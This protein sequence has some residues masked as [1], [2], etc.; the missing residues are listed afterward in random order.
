M[1]RKIFLLGVGCQKGGTSWLRSQL[2]KHPAINMGFAK[3]Y[4]IFDAL[5]ID[6]CRPFQSRRLEALNTQSVQDRNAGN[7]T[8]LIDFFSN[9]DRY[10][11][12]FDD[13]YGRATQIQIVG[14]I[15]PSYAGLPAAAFERIR[16]QAQ[17][18][19][20]TV[21]VIFLMRDPFERVWSAIR[22]SRR[23][24]QKKYPTRVFHENESQ[25]ILRS[26]KSEGMEFRTRYERTITNLEM[27]FD[28]KNLFYG[29]YEMLFTQESMIRLADFLEISELNVDFASHINVSPK[30]ET[31][32]EPDTVK[33]V[34]DYYESTYQFCL[35]RFAHVGVG[36]LWTGYKYCD[37]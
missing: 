17:A 11:E 34:V 36:E 37:K 25:D 18:K 16:A 32:I 1:E 28:P 12:Y 9:T 31:G 24:L 23:N 2:V 29:F 35:N 13:L 19:G 5:Y 14:D 21:K 10:F 27:V 33:K 6:A 30:A 20:F 15:T 26:Y 4:H 3:E 22:M 8:K 7:L